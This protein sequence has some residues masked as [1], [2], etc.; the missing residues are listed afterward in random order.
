MS[1]KES[2]AYLQIVR[3]VLRKALHLIKT[4]TINSLTQ[5]T[6]SIVQQMQEG[7]ADP[8]AAIKFSADNSY[9]LFYSKF[10]FNSN[11]IKT[12]MEQLEQRVEFNNQPDYEQALSDCHR[13]YIQQRKSF[14]M[15]SV[16]NAINELVLKNQRDTCTLVSCWTSCHQDGR[17]R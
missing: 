11:K 8:S 7:A 4:Y 15:V 1:H 10:R 16:L 6:S 3:T 17:D 5:T 13:C 2:V 12:L 9:T 14:I